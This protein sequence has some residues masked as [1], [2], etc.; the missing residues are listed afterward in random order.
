MDPA[1][2]SSVAAWAR[3]E[4]FPVASLLFPRALR[5]HLRAIYG[6]ARLVDILGDELEGDRLAALGDLEAELDRCYTGEPAWEV[7]RRLRPTIRACSLPREP[8][9]RLI[10]ANRMDQRIAAYET[11]D[12][13]KHYCVH[14]ADPVGRL[15]LGVLGRYD[16]ELVALSDD[17]CTGLQLVNFL[18]DVPRDLALGRVYLPADDRRRFGVT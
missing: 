7:M 12:D 16:A 14:S 18:Q 2:A 8:F 13:L 3:T 1:S 17:V 10:E 5:P 15:V 9:E 6:F 11:W 4:N